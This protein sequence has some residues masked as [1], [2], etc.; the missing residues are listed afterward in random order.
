MRRG[1]KRREGEDLGVKPTW[2]RE[3]EGTVPLSELEAAP[4]RAALESGKDRHAQQQA[5]LEEIVQAQPA[6]ALQPR[7]V[8]G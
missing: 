5:E 6:S 8:N 3:I 2:L 1:L 4:A 7:W